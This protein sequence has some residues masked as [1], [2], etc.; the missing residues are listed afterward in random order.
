MADRLPPETIELLL[1]LAFD[2]PGAEDVDI[3]KERARR[4]LLWSA[5]LVCRRWRPVATGMLPLSIIL[6][7]AA[8]L[9]AHVQARRSDQLDASRTG[10][11]TIACFDGDGLTQGHLRELGGGMTHLH[12][13]RIACA[14]IMH[15]NIRRW[16]GRHLIVDK[17]AC[18]EGRERTEW[19]DRDVFAILDASAS[20]SHL[21]ALRCIDVPG[22][23]CEPLGDT[24]RARVETV[25]LGSENE[26]FC[27]HE[28]GGFLGG[29]GGAPMPRLRYLRC[30]E[31]SLERLAYVVVGE[32]EDVEV[33]SYCEALC[34]LCLVLIDL[35]AQDDD[36][37]GV[38]G[39][40][41]ILG[42]LSET[43]TR[44]AFRLAGDIDDASAPRLLGNLA[45][46]FDQAG[47]VRIGTVTVD[48][49]CCGLD[50]AWRASD[51]VA[52]LERACAARG[53]A[54]EVRI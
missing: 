35:R 16:P 21:S 36:E 45:A 47:I 1:S 50:E 39:A 18:D 11:L 43:C 54:V 17:L 41:L 10:S 48:V 15:G 46:A 8:E 27:F 9:A 52:A 5:S 25:T 22:G 26:V 23:G 19:P 20:F 49:R 40:A 34:D 13:L 3:E 31:R 29:L 37:V 12:Y 42:R 30:F 4:A 53:I 38:A 2:P 24:F 7:S 14:S 33:G 28:D 44:V 32:S 6:R 51:A